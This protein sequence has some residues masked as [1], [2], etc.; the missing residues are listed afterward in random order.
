M[1]LSDDLA[2]KSVHAAVA[3]IEVYNKPDFHFR[4][5]AFSL[6]MTNAW[7]LL[8]K[9]KWL[10]DHSN[11]IESL[12]E[13]SNGSPRLNRSGNPITYGIT[14]L[15]NKMLEDKHSGVTQPVHNNLAALVEIRDNAVHFMNAGPHIAPR[16]MEIG[17]AA[18]QN[19]VLLARDWFQIDLSRYNFYLMP[20]AFHHGF[21]AVVAASISTPPEQVG[22]L[23]K[24]LDQ[25]GTSSEGEPPGGPYFSCR[26]QT[27][28]VRSKDASAI[29]VK[30]SDDPKAPSVFVREEDV[31]KNYPYSYRQLTE[32]LRSR[33]SD[34]VENAQF[35]KIKS[36]IDRNK[37]FCLHRALVPGN[38]KSPKT[39][40]YNPNAFTEFDKHYTKRKRA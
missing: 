22:K 13:T 21:E 12:Y 4:E 16:V 24:Y 3:A 15:A 5:E 9:G 26:L 20:L 29:S 31:L 10:A 33:Y 2:A 37:K 39:K 32:Q 25:L 28:I 7:E 6:L 19:Y 18:I 23:L 1:S 34:F 14:Y 17:M 38:P 36:A 40:F 30:Y 35:H 27:Q 8:L 11:Q